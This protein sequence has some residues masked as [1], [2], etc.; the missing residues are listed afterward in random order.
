MYTM[1]NSHVTKGIINTILRN[2]ALFI[3]RMKEAMSQ[4]RC[5]KPA[6][7]WYMYESMNMFTCASKKTIYDRFV[8]WALILSD[9]F[10]EPYGF[11]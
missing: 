4:E 9:I 5:T 7:E 10:L 3:V 11:L 8:L 6:D 2:K 1:M